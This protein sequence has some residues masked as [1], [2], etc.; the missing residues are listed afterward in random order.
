RCPVT[1]STDRA[2][3]VPFCG[4]VERGD[5]AGL[6]ECVV[7]AEQRLLLPADG[8]LEVG[9]LERV[10]VGGAGID[11]F[12][13]AVGAAQLDDGVG[14]VPWVGEQQRAVAADRLEV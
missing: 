3:G 4:G 12:D 5:R 9:Q 2:W 14:R 6:T 7:A 11:A 1:S 10:G 8:G 13:R